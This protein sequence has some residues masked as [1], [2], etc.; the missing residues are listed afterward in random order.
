[1]ESAHGAIKK[2]RKY[3]PYKMQK[4]SSLVRNTLL[5]YCHHHFYTTRFQG[6]KAN[7]TVLAF[8]P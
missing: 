5:S 8:D 7:I 3:R 6:S 2:T 1:M 4:A